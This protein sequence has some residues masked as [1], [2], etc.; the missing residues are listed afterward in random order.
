MDP[1]YIFLSVINMKGPD[2]KQREEGQIKKT[3]FEDSRSNGFVFMRKLIFFTLGKVLFYISK[4]N[5]FNGSI[6]VFSS[7]IWLSPSCVLFIFQL[8]QVQDTLS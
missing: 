7:S 6:Y 3:Q 4:L 5:N 8:K 1:L 2:L